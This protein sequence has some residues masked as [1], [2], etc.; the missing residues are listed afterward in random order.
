MPCDSPPT[1]SQDS[2]VFVA[3][4][5]GY[6]MHTTWF[7][8]LQPSTCPVSQCAQQPLFGR[9]RRRPSCIAEFA[10]RC[11]ST[12]SGDAPLHSQ[13]GAGICWLVGAGPGDPEL[14]TVQPSLPYFTRARSPKCF[15]SHNS[16]FWT[17]LAF[18]DLQSTRFTVLV[19]IWLKRSGC[20]STLQHCHCCLTSRQWQFVLFCWVSPPFP[21]QSFRDM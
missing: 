14:V 9:H 10:I 16:C 1:C 2:V 11:S 17:I 20:H 18:S 19:S 5:N 21:G 4:M 15:C 12:A 3:E 6:H 13:G 7:V 8:K